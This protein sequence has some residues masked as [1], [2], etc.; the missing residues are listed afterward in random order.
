ME[1]TRDDKESDGY[2]VEQTGH[3]VQSVDFKKRENKASHE[4]DQCDDHEDEGDQ[5]GSGALVF[6]IVRLTAEKQGGCL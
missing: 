2:E 5:S 4:D 3:F 1:N 6:N